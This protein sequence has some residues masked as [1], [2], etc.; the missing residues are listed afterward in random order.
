[1]PKLA[2][3]PIFNS[4]PLS[5]LLEYKRLILLSPLVSAIRQAFVP[6]PLGKF[7]EIPP[8]SAP[9]P[10]PQPVSPVLTGEKNFDYSS[11]RVNMTWLSDYITRQDT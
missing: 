10:T 1:M 3:I 5:L 2:P 11:V 4:L 8:S 6:K 9:P 7:I